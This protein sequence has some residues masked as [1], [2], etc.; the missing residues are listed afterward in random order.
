MTTRHKETDTHKAIT[1]TRQKNIDDP[2]KKYRNGTVS[3]IFNWRAQT[4][5]M[6]P[7]SPLI[8]MWIH[9]YLV[10]M[11]D[12]LFINVSSPRTYKS[13]YKKGDKAK[14]RT[15]WNSVSVYL[16]E[17]FTCTCVKS[18]KCLF[19]IMTLLI[20]LLVPFCLFSVASLFSLEH[21]IKLPFYCTPWCS[22]KTYSRFTTY[23]SLLFSL[24]V[25]QANTTSRIGGRKDPKSS[26]LVS[27]H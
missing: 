20:A 10:C 3:K 11:I 26:M 21:Y 12:P 1:N 19:R 24:T 6:A 9:R 22:R 4:G 27:I 7:T 2:Q 8:Q 17:N 18:A 16:I 15:Q 23:C 13:R 14:I 25:L 5:F